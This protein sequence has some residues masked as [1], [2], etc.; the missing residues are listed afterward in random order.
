MW[1]PQMCLVHMPQQLP[2]SQPLPAPPTHEGEGPGVEAVVPCSA[3]LARQLGARHLEVGLAM[4]LRRAVVQ[5]RRRCQQCLATL[6]KSTLRIA[7]QA[8]RLLTASLRRPHL[9]RL[10]AQLA[11]LARRCEAVHGTLVGGEVACRGTECK[12]ERSGRQLR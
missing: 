8:S 12:P 4:L 1:A 9:L 2:P 3:R 7:Y 6:L 5:G 11:Q 10:L